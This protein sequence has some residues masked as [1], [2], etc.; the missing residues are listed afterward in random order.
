MAEIDKNDVLIALKNRII[1]EAFIGSTVLVTY[2]L[3]DTLL[4]LPPGSTKQ[5]L[6][7]AAVLAGFHVSIA[8]ASTAEVE[9]DRGY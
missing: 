8:G 3:W 9:R 7:D 6:A 2:E 5:H 1:M 4:H